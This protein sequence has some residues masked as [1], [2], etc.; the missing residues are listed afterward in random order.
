MP[1]ASRIEAFKH[2]WCQDECL[3]LGD[4]LCSAFR[5]ESR[6]YRL[7]NVMK[8]F[9]KVRQVSSLKTFAMRSSSCLFANL[10]NKFP[11]FESELMR[12]DDLTF[13]SGGQGDVWP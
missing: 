9:G 4:L 8:Q 5:W 10:R 1:P 2:S 7:P 3:A 13:V 12:H 11:S 6:H